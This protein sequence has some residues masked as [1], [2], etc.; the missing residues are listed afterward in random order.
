[1]EGEISFACGYWDKIFLDH[2][3]WNTKVFLFDLKEDAALS[4]ILKLYNYKKLNLHCYLTN[5][6]TV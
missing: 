4:L 5:C 2:V 6:K 1:M 3:F